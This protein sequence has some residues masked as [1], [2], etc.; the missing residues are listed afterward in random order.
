MNGILFVLEEVGDGLAADVIGHVL[1][2][3]HLFAV[4]HHVAV[5]LQQRNSLSEFF[6]LQDD[7]SGKLGG[8]R[9]RRVDLIH[10]QAQGR[11]VYKIQDIVEGG[12]EAVDILTIKGGDKRL[13]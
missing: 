11:G 7:D 8:N 4:F 9:R 3:V 5:F 13:V 2:S 12:G 6:A 1:E 10:D